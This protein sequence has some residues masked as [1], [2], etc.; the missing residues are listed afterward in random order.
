MF[1]ATQASAVVREAMVAKSPDGI[2]EAVGAF[3]PGFQ[4]GSALSPETQH[5]SANDYSTEWATM[6]DRQLYMCPFGSGESLRAVTW[7]Q[8][9]GRHG[10]R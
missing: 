3:V 8:A 6:K 9:G 10:G 2:F 1:G 4:S 5:T 7:Q